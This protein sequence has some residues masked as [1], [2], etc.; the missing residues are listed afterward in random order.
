MGRRCHIFKQILDL[1]MKY[2]GV[3]RDT[4]RAPKPTTQYNT[5]QY[6]VIPFKGNK[7]TKRYNEMPGIPYN[8]KIAY[9]TFQT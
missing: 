4:A 3:L 5:I 8:S 7:Y 9:D 6:H 2:I 1:I